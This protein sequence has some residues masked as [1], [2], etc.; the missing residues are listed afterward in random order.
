[1]PS[2]TFYYGRLAQIL[3]TSCHR[4]QNYFS[5]NAYNSRTGWNHFGSLLWRQDGGAWNNAL[6]QTDLSVV[7]IHR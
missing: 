7:I 4:K 5:L 3:M 6:F 2:W 1:M